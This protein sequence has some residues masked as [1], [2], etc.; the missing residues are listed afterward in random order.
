VLLRLGRVGVLLLSVIVLSVVL[1]SNQAG[2]V[3]L[4]LC[5]KLLLLSV[6]LQLL[7]VMLCQ[8]CMG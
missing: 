1:L 6:V 8:L 5:V 3:L 7:S 2:V 4:L